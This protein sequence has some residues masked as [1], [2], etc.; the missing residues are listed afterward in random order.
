MILHVTTQETS[1]VLW[2]MVEEVQLSS[3]AQTEVP[4]GELQ[5]ST[6]PM[7]EHWYMAVE[8]HSGVVVIF[9]LHRITVPWSQNLLI[10]VEHGPGIQS[11]P[12]VQKRT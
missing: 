12:Q 8:V 5:A 2:G 6:T 9:I 7:A 1:W 4:F 11:L 10:Q 3:R